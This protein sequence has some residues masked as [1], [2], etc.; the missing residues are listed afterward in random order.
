MGQRMVV[1]VS[2][3]VLRGA[4]VGELVGHEFDLVIGHGYAHTLAMIVT[5]NDLAGLV[6]QNRSWD[7]LDGVDLLVEARRR[8]P[9]IGRTILVPLIASSGGIEDAAAHAICWTPWEPGE[10]ASAVRR[11][12]TVARASMLR[13][14]PQL[15]LR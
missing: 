15:G 2:D 13:M 11:A 8:R 1:G 7:G 9:E 14:P 5:L 4:A 6:V 3:T 10:L 12:T